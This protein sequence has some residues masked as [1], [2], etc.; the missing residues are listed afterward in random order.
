MDVFFATDFHGG[1]FREHEEGNNN[2]HEDHAAAVALAS[3]SGCDVSLGSMSLA[4]TERGTI[5]SGVAADDCAADAAER[6]WFSRRVLTT[7]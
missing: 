7:G 4:P 3:Q 5:A 6:P 1:P 2:S